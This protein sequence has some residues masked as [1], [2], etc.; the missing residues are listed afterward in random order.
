MPIRILPGERR[1]QNLVQRIG[2]RP[3]NPVVGG[4]PLLI[5]K[6]KRRGVLLPRPFEPIL[7]NQPSSNLSL[8]PGNGRRYAD[9]K[10]QMVYLWRDAEGEVVDVLVLSKRIR[11]AA[12][13]FMRKLL[14]KYALV[15]E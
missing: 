14:K 13:K 3:R 8:S 2:H 10:R 11:H 9:T 5:Q 12:L 15:P 6:T 1:Q 7:V 4:N